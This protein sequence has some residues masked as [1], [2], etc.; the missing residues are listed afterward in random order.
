MKDYNIDIENLSAGVITAL[1]LIFAVAIYL[2]I[3]ACRK[4]GW[5]G[6]FLCFLLSPFIGALIVAFLPEDEKHDH[7]EKFRCGICLIEFK[8][9]LLGGQTVREGKLC[10]FCLDKRQ[11]GER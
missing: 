6:F 4:K 8:K 10:V 5:L 7:E 3:Y 9:E 11:R 2:W 1:L